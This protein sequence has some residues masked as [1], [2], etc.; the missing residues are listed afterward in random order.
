[1]KTYYRSF[2]VSFM[3]L[4]AVRGGELLVTMVLM[5]E[6]TDPISPPDTTTLVI[7]PA[8]A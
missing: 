2:I 1:M 5:I 3:I 6:R 8:K 4:T 7:A